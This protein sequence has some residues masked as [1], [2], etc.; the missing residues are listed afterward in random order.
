MG[1]GHSL[2]RDDKPTKFR[3]VISYTS[4]FHE[5]FQEH[6]EQDLSYLKGV[7]YPEKS[8]QESLEDISRQIGTLS[9]HFSTLQGPWSPPPIEQS[10]N[11]ISKEI[12]E[13]NKKLSPTPTISLWNLLL[14]I[15]K[16][17]RLHKNEF[18]SKNAQHSMYWTAKIYSHAPRTQ[19]VRKI[20]I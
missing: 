11:S 5:L 4:T 14:A 8:I 9:N 15:L 18:D 12:K 3:F 19:A 7:V 17:S 10:L 6:I 13:I 2:F 1:Y 20:S 16:K